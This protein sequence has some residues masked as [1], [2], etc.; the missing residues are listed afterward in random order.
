MATLVNMRKS[1][2]ASVPRIVPIAIVWNLVL[3]V[4]SLAAAYQLFQLDDFYELGDTVQYFAALAALVPGV[5]AVASAILLFRRHPAG[6]QI[7][8]ALNY[9]GMVLGAVY[10]LHLWGV[11]IG[12]DDVAYALYDNRVWLL[13]LAAAYAVFW[14]AGRLDETSRW[15]TV[16]EQVSLGAAMLT[17]IALLWTGNAIGG[18]T[19]I[20]ETYGDLV[21]WVVTLAVAVFGVLAYGVLRQGDY[22]G[23]TPEQR[24]AWQGWLMLSPNMIGFMLFF[25]GPLLLSLYFSFTDSKPGATPNWV[26]LD[27]YQ[28]IL[29]LQFKTQDDLSAYP[30]DALT[31]DYLP[32]ET[33][34]IGGTRYVIGAREPLFWQSLR[35]T[36]VFCLLLIPLSVIPAL[37]LSIVLNS[38]VPGMKF[39]R[40]VYFLPS[41]AAVVGT[42]LIWQWLYS[43]DIGYINYAISQ[44][45]DFINNLFG[46]SIAD[47]HIAWLTD[48]RTQLLAVV[49][50][51]AWQVIGFNT[52]L[53]LAGL[54]G[55]P[56]ILYEASYVDGA[57]RWN[58]FRFVTLPMLAPTTFFVMVTT[59]ITGLQAFNEPYAMFSASDPIPVNVTTSVYYLY[60][61][62]FKGF[63]FGYASSVAWL[64]FALI[65][66]VTLIQFRLQRNQ[67]YD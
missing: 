6:R 7:S 1:E 66:V 13:G 27:N 5:A 18:A 55:I 52:V 33:F 31:G 4:G 10:L 43:Q 21:T 19:S 41:V 15:R 53:F 34:E 3:A 60:R 62:G 46:T 29:S 59:I 32:L 65:F 22:F 39:F 61:K 64:V 63:Q 57:N 51:A 20:L 49:F 12:I 44:V 38:K 37:I 28:H 67:A 14:V 2:P 11:F 54:Q 36:I 48:Q 16:L 30:V 50:L 58:Q 25:A 9:L 56:R 24:T 17:L 23:E 8:L 40:A 26:G 45:I 47:P 42:A 35:N